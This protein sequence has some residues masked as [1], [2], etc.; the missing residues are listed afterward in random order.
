M[1]KEKTEVNKGRK[2]IRKIIVLFWLTF[3]LVLGVV[4]GY[5][6][7]LS[8]N[9]LWQLP[10]FEELENPKSLLATTIYSGDGQ[11]IGNFFKENRTPVKY[12]DLP[13]H[14]VNA[15]IAT[16]DERYRNH[17]GIDIRRLVTAI[18]FLGTRGGASTLT[19]QLAKQLYH[20]PASSLI[21]RLKQKTMEWVIAAKLERAY[22]KD[23]IITMYLNKFDF[24]YQ[25]NG[26]QSASAVYFNKFP[27]ELTLP[28]AAVFV[29][30]AK[31]PVLY[32]PRKDSSRATFRRNTV[33]GQMSRN[34]MLT[35]NQVDSLEKIP[36]VL[37]FHEVNHNLGNA[38][39]FRE[40]LR[41]KVSSLL[42]EK[43]ENGDYI[44][45]K[46][47]GRPY[48]IYRDGLKV[49]TTIDIKMQQYAEWA[50]NEHL[51]KELQ[52]ALKRDLKKKK[53][54]PFSN[55]Y[56]EKQVESF[57]KRALRQ[58]GRYRILTGRE[59]GNCGRGSKFVGKKKIEGKEYF[60]CSAEECGH[61]KRPVISEDS[62]DKIMHVPVK[63]A[64][65]TWKGERDTLLTPIDSIKYYKSFLHTGLLSV[66]PHTGYVKAWVGGIN[67]KHFAYDHVAQGKRQ[68][69]STFKPFVY[70]LAIENGLSPCEKVP[71]IA[72]TIKKGRWD[73]MKD[74]TPKNAGDKEAG[75]MITL[76]HGL[77]NS[78]NWITAWVMDRYGP[79]A[80]VRYAKRMG[81]TSKLDTVPSLALGVSDISLF[82]MVGANATF[83]NKGIYKKPVYLTRIEDKDGN[84]IKEIKPIT[85]EAMSEKNAYAMLELMKGVAMGSRGPSG[86]TGGTAIRLHSRNRPYAKIPW[87]R[88]IAGKTGTT[89]GHADGWFMGITPDLVTGVWVGAEDPSVRF[90]TLSLGQGANTA[91]PIWG[92]YMNKVWADS[93]L[94]V[95]TGD[96]E[97]PAGLTVN[98]NCDEVNRV[99]HGFEGDTGEDDPDSE[100]D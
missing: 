93:T 83:A 47:D 33:F 21:G 53:R 34:G 57:I 15:L 11:K 90:S 87:N 88:P 26:I 67:Q 23:E 56:S 16:E 64:V 2:G 52:A 43:D 50:V 68:V 10:S 28:E 62:I 61:Y 8:N 80:V 73:L 7:A 20:D 6:Y 82:E 38:T 44:Y 71:N 94:A 65:F 42:R 60:T 92:Y 59:C 97:K 69:G 51:S 22:T 100:F 96:F 17:S 27:K 66:D 1:T 85:H 3:I 24:I 46:P 74:W 25:A 31:N 63:M 14:L 75:E 18:G 13:E 84:V 30:M 55:K 9:M 36:L 39:Y 78:N 77:A 4:S 32:N 48:N 91:L 37:D 40:F 5:F 81:I 35:E 98:F 70:A 54:P 12:E 41:K 79:A 76:K 49:Y 29:G 89:Q 86:K 19:Q 45:A 95:S 58:T 99:D 72:H